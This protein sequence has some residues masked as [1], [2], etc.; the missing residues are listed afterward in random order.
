M[1]SENSPDTPAAFCPMLS[2]GVCSYLII[3]ITS[4]L[5]W[6]LEI[7]TA[8][9]PESSDRLLEK[10]KPKDCQLEPQLGRAELCS[11]CL[12]HLIGLAL[13][14]ARQQG[15]GGVPWVAPTIN[16]GRWTHPS[17]SRDCLKVVWTKASPMSKEN[18]LTFLGWGSRIE[19]R[20]AALR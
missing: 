13:P 16:L 10:T 20:G 11:I 4:W 8:L 6:I 1:S 15:L 9:P 14:G 5:F 7:K 3:F 18:V 19:S 2:A 12:G 17:W